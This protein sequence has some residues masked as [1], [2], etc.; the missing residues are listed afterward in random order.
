MVTVYGINNCS[1]VKKALAWLKERG[2]EHAF[3]DFRKDGTDAERLAAWADALGWETLL[4]RRAPSFRKIPDE[5]KADL[6]RGR[7]L[8]LMQ[9]Y[10]N[11]IKRPVVETDGTVLTVG[12]DAA[13][14]E[15]LFG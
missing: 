5:E 11:I 3:H 7:A 9:A 12:F 8:A 14:Y 6:D 4:N 13:R 2:V 15:E 10:P 1:T